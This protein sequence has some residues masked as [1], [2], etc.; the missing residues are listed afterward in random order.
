MHH[1]SLLHQKSL[2]DR[3]TRAAHLCAGARRKAAANTVLKEQISS[4]AALLNEQSPLLDTSPTDFSAARCTTCT[5]G[6][7]AFLFCR[8]A[9][10]GPLAPFSC[11]PARGARLP[12]TR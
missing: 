1:N 6:L 12:P 5:H 10:Q 11:V 9:H 2:K 8:L 3:Q 4:L 7:L